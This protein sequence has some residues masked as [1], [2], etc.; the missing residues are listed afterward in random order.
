MSS[1][2][3]KFITN[4]EAVPVIKSDVFSGH[5]EQRFALGVFSSEDVLKYG[6]DTI[7]QAYLRLR[8]NTYIDQTG[9]LKDEVKRADGTEL[10][11]DDERS[12][13]FIVLENRL[14][15]VAVF[16]C[17]RLI[18]KIVDEGEA[19][20]PIEEFFPEAFAEQEAPCGSTEVSRFIVRHDEIPHCRSA[21]KALMAALVAYSINNN[22]K[23]MFGVIEPGFERDLKL[24][25]A[26][27]RRIAEPKEVPEYNDKNLGI[28]V[29]QEGI[30]R[31]LGEEL[32]KSMSLKVGSLSYWGQ[33]LP[34]DS[35]DVVLK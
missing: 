3:N 29:D 31:R 21:K 20:L 26:P 30:R 32:F 10:D 22:F 2:S 24:M 11:E 19:A 35:R 17:A 33:I 15:E 5:E 27:T 18:Q 6:S 4:K 8:A 34:D 14:G 23:S 28:E 9:M 16:A 25:R 12:T 7:E 13:H 1:A